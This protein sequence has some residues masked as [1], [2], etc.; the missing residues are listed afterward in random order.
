MCLLAVLLLPNISRAAHFDDY[1][2]MKESLVAQY[3]QSEGW[4]PATDNE[5]EMLKW[6]FK[7]TLGS[8]L[9]N[10]MKGATTERFYPLLIKKGQTGKVEKI[11]GYLK[12]TTKMQAKKEDDTWTKI[13]REYF[14]TWGIYTAAKEWIE[15]ITPQQSTAL[16][17]D[18]FD[19]CQKS[20]KNMPLPFLCTGE[21]FPLDADGDLKEGPMLSD[22][23]LEA[24]LP[25]NDDSCHINKD[26]DTNKCYLECDNGSSKGVECP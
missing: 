9:S 20:L 21:E 17:K 11:V 23:E 19:K 14:D 26:P 4:K 22:A 5:A 7:M 8:D 24:I 25:T 1:E 16:A 15:E 12:V 3:L 2:K 6:S 18:A 10:F 13:E